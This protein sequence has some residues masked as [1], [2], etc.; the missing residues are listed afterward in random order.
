MAERPANLSPVTENSFGDVASLAGYELTQL[1]SETFELELYWESLAEIADDYWVFVHFSAEA[2]HPPL[3]TSN[4]IPVGLTRPTSGWR[5]GEILQDT[6]RLV[7]P[8]DLPEGT[9]EIFLGFYHPETGQRLPAIELGHS[10]PFD[11]FS[12]TTITLP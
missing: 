7:L 9:Y 6:R 8:P 5:V 11:Q 1:D 3:T 12:L 4:S 10:L 2:D